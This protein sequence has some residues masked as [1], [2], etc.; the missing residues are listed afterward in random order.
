MQSR[1]VDSFLFFFVLFIIF[2]SSKPIEI[3]INEIV[4][5]SPERIF[6]YIFFSFFSSSFLC[7]M[8]TNQPNIKKYNKIK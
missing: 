8:Q 2:F 7:G 3:I 5:N 4:D 1:K 6:V